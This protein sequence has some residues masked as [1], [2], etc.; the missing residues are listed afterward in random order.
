L[1]VSQTS[2]E[3]MQSTAR[4][5]EEVNSSLDRML[6]SLMNE[7]SGLRSQWTGAGGRSFEETQR[8]WAAQQE[9]LHRA[10]SE[11]TMAVRTAGRRYAAADQAAA[12]RFTVRRT[13]P[14]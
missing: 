11:T 2:T 14:L 4:R 13:L 6:R 7:L 9:K 10:L 5:F 8:A 1:S 12:D 3:L